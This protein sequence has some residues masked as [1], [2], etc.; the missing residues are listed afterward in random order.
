[1]ARLNKDRNALRG[2][3]HEGK[4]TISCALKQNMFKGLESNSCTK[5]TVDLGKIQSIDIIVR[6]LR[7]T[8]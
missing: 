1:M 4:K 3:H 8:P 6:H 7:K 2:T 5:W